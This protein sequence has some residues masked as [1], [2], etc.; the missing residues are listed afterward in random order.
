MRLAAEL[1]RNG[2]HNKID[3]MEKL[4][5]KIER[6]YAGRLGTAFLTTGYLGADCFA[7]IAN[8]SKLQNKEGH[9]V[10]DNDQQK[11]VFIPDDEDPEVIADDAAGE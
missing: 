5:R 11:A 9:V 3:A 7:I 6:K 1:H 4:A 8:D 2:E 10:Y